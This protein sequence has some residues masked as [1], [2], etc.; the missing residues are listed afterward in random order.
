MALLVH[1]ERLM[2]IITQPILS[3][4]EIHKIASEYNVLN[5]KKFLIAEKS[6][7]A[8][9]ETRPQYMIKD[10]DFNLVTR[11]TRIE[12]IR[13]QEYRTIKG[14]TQ[15]NYVRYPKYSN[16]KVREKIIKKT[17]KLTNSELENLNDNKDE[18][19]RLFAEEIVLRICNENILPSWFVELYL[20]RRMDLT[21]KLMKSE[22]NNLIEYEN[23]LIATHEDAIDF[24]NDKNKSLNQK[25]S[26][27]IKRKDK[28]I[29]LL[30]KLK[31]AK[32][33]FF[34]CIFSLGIYA[35]LISKKRQN[36]IDNK[37]EKIKCEIDHLSNMVDSNEKEIKIC[38]SKILKSRNVIDNKKESFKHKKNDLI[39]E[40]D[41]NKSCIIPLS[42]NVAEDKSYIPLKFFNGFEHEKIIGVYIIHNKEKDKYYVGQ[43]KDIIKRINQHFKGVVPNNPIF[44]EDYY[45]STY[46]NKDDI[47]EIKI[48]KCE[49]KDELDSLEK[50]LIYEYD[51]K[52][53]GYNGTNGNL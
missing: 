25:L 45:Y 35:C 17:I 10:I 33:N 41:N 30:S 8:K 39:K 46:N 29:K 21:L 47:F 18:L 50:R 32:L 52:N 43:S 6:L 19:I 34:N 12:F 1:K 51:A 13:L 48:I 4:E 44:A 49:T 26:K 11:T 31:R 14:Y 3:I 9:K 27:N 22:L 15:S 2:G 7:N 42:T 40:Y 20:K 28:K 53:S 16:W 24:Y 36:K 38:D 37:I 23:N 5:T